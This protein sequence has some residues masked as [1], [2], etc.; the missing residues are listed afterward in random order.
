MKN[1]LTP[2]GTT[3]PEHL[4]YI[5]ELS[6]I[7]GHFRDFVENQLFHLHSSFP[8]YTFSEEALLA[9]LNEAKSASRQN[10][11]ESVTL[12]VIA[13]IRMLDL[14]LDH[15]DVHP[16][17]KSVGA[18]Y[19]QDRS[20][21]FFTFL[22]DQASY[23]V[24]RWRSILFN[25][26]NLHS[27]PFTDD[28]AVTP[29]P[30]DIQIAE[31]LLRHKDKSPNVG[32][33]GS[34]YFWLNI[35]LWRTESKMPGMP[36]VK[37]KNDATGDWETDEGEDITIPPWKSAQYPHSK[38]T[39]NAVIRSWVTGMLNIN[40]ED[41]IYAFLDWVKQKLIKGTAKNEPIEQSQL[42]WILGELQKRPITIPAYP[43]ALKDI[44]LG[45]RT[46]KRELWLRDDES[47]NPSDTDLTHLHEQLVIVAELCAEDRLKQ[48]LPQKTIQEL[49]P[50]LRGRPDGG[51]LLGAKKSI[52]HEDM[53]AIKY[54][55]LL[56]ARV[57][58]AIEEFDVFD[59]QYALNLLVD[60][61]KEAQALRQ[62]IM[63]IR[64]SSNPCS[65]ESL[66]FRPSV[67]KRRYDLPANFNELSPEFCISCLVDILIDSWQVKQRSKELCLDFA[68][69]CM[70]RLKFKKQKSR[71]RS[72]EKADSGYYDAAQCLEPDPAWRK[73]Y[74]EALGELGYALDGKVVHLLDFV[75]K[76][77]PDEHVRT[78]AHSSYKTIH[79]EQTKDMDD[80]KGLRAAFWAIRKAQRGALGLPINEATAKLLKRQELRGER[81]T[82]SDFIYKEFLHN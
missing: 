24:E 77:D 80:S 78:S 75:R 45:I 2:S 36:S 22:V 64:K 55:A 3:L 61:K 13:F 17:V 39:F 73:A 68:D 10:E 72:T 67:A 76:N 19:W 33:P 81:Q 60:H 21:E 58:D 50:V 30:L 23:P 44:L 42:E 41:A 52:H 65:N 8:H 70:S 59:Y 37:I 14:P 46:L 79:R 74:A 28:P 29:K 9:A 51:I 40:N 31:G 47:F 6:G 43:L 82:Q 4:Q 53:L 5:V 48:R 57:L 1:E 35:E 25:H 63:A 27:R 38:K 49:I 11:A 20:L 66:N 69:Y 71:A 26:E 18:L 62:L 32:S 54:L 34:I 15:F 16:T 7:S 56:R 12:Q